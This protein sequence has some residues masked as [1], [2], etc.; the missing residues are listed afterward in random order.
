MILYLPADVCM[1]E[2]HGCDLN[3]SDC[4]S[5]HGNVPQRCK[6]KDGFQTKNDACVRGNNIYS[7]CT[8]M[9]SDHDVAYIDKYKTL[10]YPS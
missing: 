2:E 6:C 7:Q 8:W 3:T 10:V 1:T 9:V 4:I 5:G